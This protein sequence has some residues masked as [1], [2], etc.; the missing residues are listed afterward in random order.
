MAEVLH[1]AAQCV[2]DCNTMLAPFL[3]HSARQVD[4]ALGYDRPFGDQPVIEEVADLDDPSRAYPVIT[5]DYG[6]DS[7]RPAP[8]WRRAP[9]PA[10]QAVPPAQPIFTKLDPAVV[11]VENA[12]LAGLDQSAEPGTSGG[13][14][15]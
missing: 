13:P 5:G 10:G 3:P 2:S 8:A 11:A 4:A 1:V 7:G 9:L 14:G 15:E 12:R 6:R